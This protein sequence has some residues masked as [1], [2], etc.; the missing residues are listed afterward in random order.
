VVLEILPTPQ[1]APFRKE[2][3]QPVIGED[4]RRVD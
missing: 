3:G 1:Q 2:D 4:G